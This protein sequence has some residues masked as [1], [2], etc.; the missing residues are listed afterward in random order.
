M[1][2]GIFFSDLDDT[3]QAKQ[4]TDKIFANCTLEQYTIKITRLVCDILQ[5]SKGSRHKS[6]NL[7]HRQ[8]LDLFVFVR[9]SNAENYFFSYVIMLLMFL[10]K[11]KFTLSHPCQ[12]FFHQ[13]LLFQRIRL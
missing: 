1:Y 11:T 12:G 6:Y 10:L 9:L 13:S 5:F 3:K 8:M 4:S 7:L 2:N